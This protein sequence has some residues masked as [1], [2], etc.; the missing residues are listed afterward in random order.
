M[1]KDEKQTSLAVFPLSQEEDFMG[2]E[3]IIRH[4]ELET[5]SAFTWGSLSFHL[6]VTHT[7]TPRPSILLSV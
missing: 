4:I 6:F 2:E 5:S 3:K 7:P 1:K